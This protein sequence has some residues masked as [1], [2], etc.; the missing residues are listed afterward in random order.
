MEMAEKRD[1]NAAAAQWDQE[2]RR[3]KLAGEVVAAIRREL[4]LVPEMTALDYGCGT[5]LVT[6][7]LQPFLGHIIGA[8]SSSGMLEALNAKLRERRIENVGT[9]LLDLELSEPLDDRY[10]LIVSSMT[11]HHVQDVPALIASLARALKPGG[12]LALADL[13]SEDGSFHEDHTGVFHHGFAPEFFQREFARN[14]LIDTRVIEA[15]TIDKSG[16][17]LYPVLL[18]LGRKKG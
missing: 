9:K 17:R 16:E 14:S 18:G 11:L 15:A 4:P 5:G 2:P 6:L 1:F 7:G 10:D 3:L 13:A 12:W 8:D